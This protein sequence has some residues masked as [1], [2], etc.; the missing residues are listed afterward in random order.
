MGS[1]ERSEGVGF[2][3]TKS[4]FV[5]P[6]VTSFSSFLVGAYEGWSQY[7]VGAAEVKPAVVGCVVAPTSLVGPSVGASAPGVGIEEVKPSLV[8]WLVAAS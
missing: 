4:S 1:R 8:G 3:E 7:G 2:K 6:V 5:G